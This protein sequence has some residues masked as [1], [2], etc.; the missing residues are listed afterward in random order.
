MARRVL[1]TD[2]P[3]LWGCP[4]L[5][6]PREEGGFPGTNGL[7]DAHL[8][9]FFPT[10]L[11]S[12]AHASGLPQ[13]GAFWKGPDAAVT[14]SCAVKLTGQEGEITCFLSKPY[15]Q[16]SSTGKNQA[17]LS[18]WWLFFLPDEGT[19]CRWQSIRCQSFL[20]LLML[21]E[22]YWLPILLGSGSC[23]L[24][25]KTPPRKPCALW[26]H[27]GFS[28]ILG[29]CTQKGRLMVTGAG[30]VASWPWILRVCRSRTPR[31]SHFALCSLHPK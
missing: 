26:V 14:Q 17:G 15:G 30:W 19:S 3:M 5:Q 12:P 7:R 31:Q 4:W 18:Q 28:F 10:I 24:Y 6:G 22:P 9:T 23:T 11:P 27:S 21:P 25:P 1:L 20:V 8:S 2:K 13:G 16:L 29:V